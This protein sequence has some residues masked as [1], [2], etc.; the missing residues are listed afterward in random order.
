MPTQSSIYADPITYH[1]SLM[2]RAVAISTASIAQPHSFME[3]S[4]DESR[5]STLTFFKVRNA[6]TEANGEDAMLSVIEQTSPQSE[7]DTSPI[8]VPPIQ[9]PAAINRARRTTVRATLV[10]A[11]PEQFDLATEQPTEPTE[12]CTVCRNTAPMPLDSPTSLCTHPSSVCRKCLV[13]IIENGVAGSI[14][15]PSDGCRQ[16]LGYADV[17]KWTRGSKEELAIFDRCADHS[18]LRR[19]I[20]RTA[21]QSMNKI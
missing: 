13:L 21:D 19:V 17:M 9:T 14:R 12:E 20:V 1:R 4:S 10:P 11:T 2:A 7:D 5:S 16:E 8:P 18:H 15:C 3:P 6:V